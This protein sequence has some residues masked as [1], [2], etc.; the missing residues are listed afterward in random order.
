[1]IQGDEYDFEMP[2]PYEIPPHHSNWTAGVNTPMPSLLLEA[3]EDL[4]EQRPIY[5]IFIYSIPFTRLSSQIMNHLY[6]TSMWSDE[7]NNQ[8]HVAR[9]LSKEV[10]AIAENTMSILQQLNASSSLTTQDDRTTY[11]K[12]IYALVSIEKSAQRIPNQNPSAYLKIYQLALK[13]LIYRYFISD[14]MPHNEFESQSL[15]ECTVTAIGIIDNIE[16][17]EMVGLSSI[18]WIFIGS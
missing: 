6:S 2:T 8:I 17:L 1:M 3:E 5:A 10:D 9:L 16:K 4:R 7:I 13:L 12:L 14:C 15:Q 11:S 18:P